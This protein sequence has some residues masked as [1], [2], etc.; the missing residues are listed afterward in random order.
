[1]TDLSKFDPENVDELINELRNQL[2]NA[3]IQ[4]W[5]SNQELMGGY[6]RALAEASIQT[7]TALESNK[8][9]SRA[10]DVLMHNQELA[11]NQTLSYSKYISYVL[12]QK[13]L[14]TAF[15]GIGWGIFNRTGINLFPG[16]VNTSGKA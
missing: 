11:F 16:R 8:I 15:S 5:N 6:V 13:L 10:A 4:W 3:S 9:S 1:M 7:R 14:D 2:G 12:A